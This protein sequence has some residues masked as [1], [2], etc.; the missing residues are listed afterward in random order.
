MKK[1]NMLLMAGC[2]CLSLCACGG[3]KQ[4][5]D[6]TTAATEATT[7]AEQYKTDVKVADLEA[8]VANALGNNYYPTAEM[9]T[10]EGLEITPDMYEEFI[11]KVPMININ[12]DTLIIV[13][14]VPGQAENVEAKLNQFRDNSLNDFQ[15]PMNLTKIQCSQVEAIGDYVVFVQLG[16]GLGTDAV[17]EASEKKELT[18]DELVKIEM[19]A[20]NEQNELAL[21]TIRKMLEN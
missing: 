14:A 20:I 4:D 6:A 19:D 1:I 7:A 13:K 21:D 16:A 11:Y 2:M 18:E 10:L 8:A 9:D 12:I 3:N 15:Y 17:M 5:N